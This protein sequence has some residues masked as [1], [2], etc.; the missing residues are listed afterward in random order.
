MCGKVDSIP[1]PIVVMMLEPTSKYQAMFTLAVIIPV[2]KAPT[3]TKD[4]RGSMWIP[5]VD[6]VMPLTI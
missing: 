2:T 3:A 6:G 5:A 1:M 4:K